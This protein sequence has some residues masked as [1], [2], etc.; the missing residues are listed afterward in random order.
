V[1]QRSVFVIVL[2]AEHDGSFVT[3]PFGYSEQKIA[4]KRSI[5]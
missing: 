1:T 3:F 5:E 2:L 4:K